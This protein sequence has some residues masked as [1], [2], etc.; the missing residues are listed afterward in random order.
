MF[1]H[2]LKLITCTNATLSHTKLLARLFSHDTPLHLE[3]FKCFTWTTIVSAFRREQGLARTAICVCSPF[4]DRHPHVGP[5]KKYN[6]ILVQNHV[7]IVFARSINGE[8][9]TT[10]LLPFLRIGESVFVCGF[11]W[12]RILATVFLPAP[13]PLPLLRIEETNSVSHFDFVSFSPLAE[14][15]EHFTHAL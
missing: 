9:F 3:T 15:L 12:T 4:P 13:K 11:P 10:A 14:Y 6:C 5:K 8:D 7:T 1:K 2:T